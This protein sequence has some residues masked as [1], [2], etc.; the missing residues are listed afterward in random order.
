MPPFIIKECCEAGVKIISKTELDNAK[1]QYLS[2]QAAVA[3][4]K[5]NV[6]L[7]RSIMTIR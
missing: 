6:A 2:A 5:A 7:P 3:E 4:A 1:A